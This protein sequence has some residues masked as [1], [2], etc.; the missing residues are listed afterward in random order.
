MLARLPYD[1]VTLLAQLPSFCGLM[2]VAIAEN[3]LGYFPTFYGSTPK[4]LA[5]T[6]F[7]LAIHTPKA[8]PIF[9][10]FLVGLIYDLIAANPL[11]YSSAILT[12][13]HVAV[14]MQR[15]FLLVLDSSIVWYRFTLVM[16]GI[17]AFTTLAT[18]MMSGNLPA[19]QPLVFQLSITV[20]LFPI[21]Y[22]LYHMIVSLI[23]LMDPNA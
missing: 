14:S 11:G 9:L 20:L 8:V 15:R 16:L 1:N 4:L 13:I 22:W 3:G 17:F 7:I 12:L 23:A 21:V 10:I 19:P 6:V 18:L 5:I 2:L